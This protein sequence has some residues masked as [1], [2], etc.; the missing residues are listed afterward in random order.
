MPCRFAQVNELLEK[1]GMNR[2]TLAAEA[3]FDA[4]NITKGIKNANVPAADT[5]VKIAQILN[6]SVE[7]LVTGRHT[8]KPNNFS[9]KIRLLEKYEPL[10]SAME[11][12][13]QNSRGAVESLVKK[14]AEETKS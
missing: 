14:L 13:S 6:V 5:A 3:H 10:V 12:I 2:K 11:L 8:A 7:F 4:S 1:K 9:E